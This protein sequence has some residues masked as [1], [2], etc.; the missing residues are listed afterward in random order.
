MPAVGI[1]HIVGAGP[2]DPE[3]LTVS[4]DG[5]QQVQKQCAS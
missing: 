5:E 3:L 2:G 1:C 4:A